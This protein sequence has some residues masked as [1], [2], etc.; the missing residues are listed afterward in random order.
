MES[1]TLYNIASG[2]CVS[3]VV[4][5]LTCLLSEFFFSIKKSTI[6]MFWNLFTQCC[7]Q[8][9]DDIILNLT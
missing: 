8:F 6:E 9:T 4:V 2:H 5:V 3:H 7:L 1:T